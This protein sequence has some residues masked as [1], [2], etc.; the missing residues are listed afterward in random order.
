MEL[1][2]S[3]VWSW[4]GGGLGAFASWN[5]IVSERMIAMRTGDL[6]TLFTIDVFAWFPPSIS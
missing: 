1:V 4:F 5:R 3:K 6:Y 2:R